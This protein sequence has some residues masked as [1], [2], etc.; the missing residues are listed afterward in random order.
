MRSVFKYNLALT[1]LTQYLELPV[2][3]KIKYVDNQNG[4]ITFWAEVDQ[5]ANKHELRGFN[6]FGTG[7]TIDDD[8]MEYVGTV[9]LHGFVWHIYEGK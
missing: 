4:Q 6:V 2:G 8:S 7:H 3:A 1:D 9:Q 5:L